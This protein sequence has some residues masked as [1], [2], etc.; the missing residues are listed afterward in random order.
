MRFTLI[1]F[2]N[3]SRDREWWLF[4][5]TLKLTLQTSLEVLL[6]RIVVI[7]LNLVAGEP[8]KGT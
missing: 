3:V 5:V 1:Q 8:Q 6:R 7:P 4:T 2:K